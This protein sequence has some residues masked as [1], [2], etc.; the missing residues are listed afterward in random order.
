[1]FNLFKKPKT[2]VNKANEIFVHSRLNFAHNPKEIEV[3]KFYLK[4]DYDQKLSDMKADNVFI[5][6]GVVEFVGSNAIYPVFKMP[7]KMPA[8]RMISIR[9]IMCIC[10]VVVNTTTREIEYLSTDF[11]GM[12]LEEINSTTL[13]TIIN[14]DTGVSIMRMHNN[15]PVKFEVVEGDNIDRWTY[16]KSVTLNNVIE[17][18][19]DDY[20]DAI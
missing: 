17:L 4:P 14:N 11:A 9:K 6:N 5:C 7:K 1:M 8:T 18:V 10:A 16:E 12:S 15:G 19:L 2:D 13:N 20:S 3:F